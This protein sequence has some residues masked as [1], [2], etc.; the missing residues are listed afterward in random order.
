MNWL[1]DLDSLNRPLLEVLGYPLTFLELFGT[2]SGLLTVWL[3][4]RA[5][6][7]T[8]PTGL[9]NNVAFFLLFYQVQLYS[10][11]LLQVYFFGISLYGWWH[12]KQTRNQPGRAISV[13]RRGVRMGLALVSILGV[14]LLGTAMSH[15]HRW[16]PA[17]FPEP[18]AFPY[19]D[20]FTTVL[21]VLATVVMARKKIE[22]WWLWMAV[23]VVSIVLY[24]QRGI[25]LIALE[26][27]VFLLICLFGLLQWH[28]LYAVA[29]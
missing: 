26:Y 15:I 23:D 5:N 12:W 19:A 9:V 27:V 1:L 10:D 6:I 21:S 28:R 3:A 17:L 20:A 2:L 18:A 29:K 16:L 8:W 7:L 22:C 14:L 25:Y 24:L 11:M 4:A 13:L